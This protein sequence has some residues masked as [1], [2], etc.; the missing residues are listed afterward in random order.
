[1]VDK[2]KNKTKVGLVQIGDKF[3]EQYYLPYSIGTLQAYAQKYA[4]DPGSFDFITPIYS[5]K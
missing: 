2:D 1:M 4:N 5:S 3:G